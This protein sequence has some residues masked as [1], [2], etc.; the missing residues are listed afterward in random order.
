MLVVLRASAI[1]MFFFS[2]I[3]KLLIIIVTE[4]AIFRAS[5]FVR[6]SNNLYQRN[7][8]KNIRDYYGYPIVVQAVLELFLFQNVGKIQK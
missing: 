7:L 6:L 8:I 3:I 4:I 2:L 5:L 1:N